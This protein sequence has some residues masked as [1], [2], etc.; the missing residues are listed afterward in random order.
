MTDAQIYDQ[1]YRR[2]DGIRTGFS[3]ALRTLITHSMRHALGLGRTARFKIIPAAVIIFAYLPAI[4][5]IGLAALLPQDVD[6]GSFLPTYAS[7]YG[8]VVGAIYLFAAF[9]APMLLCNDRRT[10]M[11]GVYL[12]SPLNR[13]TY[14]LGKAIATLF[15]MLIV[16]LG[17]PLLML[18]AF[19]LESEG[20]AGLTEWL[21]VFVKIVLSSLTIGL[22]Y[23]A[24]SLAIAAATDR[25]VI[26]TAAVI[27]IM[28]GS[29]IVTDILTFGA[30][31]TPMLH[32][33]NIPNVPRELIFRIHDE[34]GRSLG[35]PLGQGS[36]WTEKE[37]STSSLWLAWLGYVAGSVG[38]VWFRYRQLLVRR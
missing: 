29:A 1:G 30:D 14:L 19:S 4:A 35:S 31:L 25:W 33:L 6:T 12:A 32:L 36:L 38:F 24:V 8:Y 9:I 11:L 10:G 34:A 2:Y 21:E 7:Y 17:P 22:M 27:L 23:S 26:A 5:F 16:T 13:A 28:P 15:L 20:P 37:N 18:I 3:G